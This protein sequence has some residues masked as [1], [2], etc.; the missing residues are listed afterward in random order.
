DAV[1]QDLQQSNIPFAELDLYRSGFDPRLQ[2]EDEPQW[3][4][5]KK[6]YSDEVM[7]LAS[8]VNE[9]SILIFIFPTWWA[10]LPAIMK[11]YIDRVF[12]YGIAYG[13]H[14]KLNPRIWRWVTL[15]GETHQEFSVDR[16][17]DQS[18]AHV[19]NYGIARYCGAT[20]SKVVFLY[21]SLAEGIDDI[22]T[23]HEELIEQAVT[24]VREAVD[25][26]IQ[27]ATA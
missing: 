14:H 1:R 12:N 17:A 18:M 13:G 15:V 16:S 11:G 10:S 27:V 25:A 3:G 21:N 8:Q 9:K 22:A 24:A 26:D 5:P 2:E 6:I 23:H 7:Q 20:D 19:L 4:N